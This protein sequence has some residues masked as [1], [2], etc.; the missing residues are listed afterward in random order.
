LAIGIIGAREEQAISGVIEQ[1]EVIDQERGELVDDQLAE[2]KA[3]VNG[4][5]ESGSVLR[6]HRLDQLRRFGGRCDPVARLLSG[7]EPKA[8][9]R[10]HVDPSAQFGDHAAR[11]A[12]LRRD[13]LLGALVPAPVNVNPAAI[14]I[15]GG[16]VE[17][18]QTVPAD[19][20]PR[21]CR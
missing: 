2:P 3:G 1:H 8:A 13:E 4:K 12:G 10:I 14:E 20:C 7:R 11:L 6:L 16:N 18:E 19:A 21:S 5:P 9:A 17:R 15:D